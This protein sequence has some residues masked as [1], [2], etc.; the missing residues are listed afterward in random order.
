MLPTIAQPSAARNEFDERA[1]RVHVQRRVLP[2]ARRSTTAK[3]AVHAARRRAPVGSGIGPGECPRRVR[4]ALPA[5]SGR[6]AYVAIIEDLATDPGV[7]LLCRQHEIAV[8]TWAA[9]MIAAAI[10]ADTITGVCQ[11]TYAHL[12]ASISRESK[13]MQRAFAVSRALGLALEVYRGR[14]LSKDERMALVEQYGTHPQRGIPE[15][16]QLG[17]IPDRIAA[18]FSTPRPGCWCWFSRFVHLPPLGGVCS[19]TYLLTSHLSATGE[20]AAAS[21]RQHRR[22]RRRRIDPAVDRLAAEVAQNVPWCATESRT[23]LAPALHRFATAIVPWNGV[24]VADAIRGVAMRQ[25]RDLAALHPAAIERPAALLATLLRDL[26]PEADHPSAPA[27]P[28][29]HTVDGLS[30]DGHGW[31]TLLD[32]HGRA[33]AAAPCPACPR[34]ARASH[35][36]HSPE[37]GAEPAF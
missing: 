22:K 7:Q 23:R 25:Q 35:V 28:D 12:A 4:R 3:I 10:E 18:R 6:S 13:V 29:T 31:I 24:D 17:L 8:A 21:R 27:F 20:K 2:L 33:T 11:K 32:E 15:G 36:D 26:D 16:W 19:H 34:S 1:L 9:A 5:W 37:A 30:C 14:E